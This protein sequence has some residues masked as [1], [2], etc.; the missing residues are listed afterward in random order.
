MTAVAASLPP[1]SGALNP[2]RSRRVLGVTLAASL[3]AHLLAVILLPGFRNRDVPVQR[4]LE[5]EI[6]HPPVPEPMKAAAPQ[7]PPRPRPIEKPKPRPTRQ[8]PPRPSA[9]PSAPQPKL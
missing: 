2:G 9:Q 5:V 3:V 1:S 4:P 7:P 6:V 8:E